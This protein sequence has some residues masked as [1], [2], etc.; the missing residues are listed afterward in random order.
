VVLYLITPMPT[1]LGFLEGEHF[2]GW[3]DETEIGDLVQS[4]LSDEAKR[5]EITRTG[6]ELVLKDHT[7]ECRKEVLRSTLLKQGDQFFAPARRWPLEKV[8]PTS[9]DI[10][11]YQIFSSLFQEFS[12]LRKTN[13][14]VVLRGT[15]MVLEAIR[16][17]IL[18]SLR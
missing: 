10:S 11:G 13:R 15:T 6:Q 18:S 4:C 2:I 5:R 3:R 8:Q 17:G 14:G 1:E 9:A 12:R 16:H 7:F